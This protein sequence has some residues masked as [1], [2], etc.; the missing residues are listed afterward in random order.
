MCGALPAI[1][2]AVTGLSRFIHL[3]LLEGITE[4]ARFASPIYRREEL[5]AKLSA[6]F[7][8]AEAGI[9]NAVIHNQAAYLAGWLNRLRDDRKLLIHAASQAQHAADFVL[10]RQLRC[11]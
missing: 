2:C 3:R 8:C 1:C 5:M 7:P 6:A 11:E 10:N 4:V 9:S